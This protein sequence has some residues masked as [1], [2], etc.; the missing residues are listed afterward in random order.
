MLTYPVAFFKAIAD[1][2]FKPSDLSNCELWVSA[3]DELQSYIDAGSTLVSADGDAVFQENDRT[4]NGFN[5]VQTTLAA[6][7]LNKRN[8]VNGKSVLRFD[9]TDDFMTFGNIL[10]SVFAGADKKFA[11]I[12]ALANYGT[13]ENVRVMSKYV[14]G[15]GTRQIRVEIRS[16]TPT[17]FFWMSTT[18]EFRQIGGETLAGSDTVL[19][20]N[21][22]GSIDTNNGLDRL[23]IRAN[24]VGQSTS[25]DGSSGTLGDIEAT[26][27]PLEIATLE[28]SFFSGLD[29]GQIVV[30]SDPSA[31]DIS[32]VED[33]MIADWG[34]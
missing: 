21:Y 26:A 27:S 10:N 12:M 22:D 2:D 33:F 20:L 19:T 3:S 34:L 6:R 16:N 7:P 8:I 31:Q 25:L 14:D 17:F 9:G 29:Y 5:A 23:S 24:G 4:T 28:S 32:K 11:I 15:T 1:G 13:S 30:L 18:N